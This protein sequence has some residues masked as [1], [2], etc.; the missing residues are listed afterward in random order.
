MTPRCKRCG[1]T[2]RSP[3]SVAKGIGPE[4][5]GHVHGHEPPSNSPRCAG[6]ESES[7]AQALA[8]PI[9]K[10]GYEM[11]E[12]MW[13]PEL[14]PLAEID[15][16]PWQV[17]TEDAAHVMDVA[18]SI[19][20]HE[21]IQP[22]IGRRVGGRVQLGAGHMRLAAFRYL[23]E[24]FGARGNGQAGDRYEKFPVIVRELSD[25]Q[26]AAYAIEENFKRKDLSAIE[27]GRALRRYMTDFSKT[28]AEAGERLSL[29][30]PA[31]SNLLRLLE[32]PAPVQDLVNEGELPERFA[33]QLV[34]LAHVAPED[35]VKAAQVIAETPPDDRD[36]TADLQI[37]ELLDEHGRSLSSRSGCYWPLDWRPES[38]V[39]PDVVACQACP[40]RVV[41]HGE[42]TCTNLVCF[43][44]RKAD[45]LQRELERMADKFKIAVA[46]PGESVKA[47]AVHYSNENDV[48]ALLRRKSKPDCL[49][50]MPIPDGGHEYYHA[51]ALGSKVVALGSTDT[52][53]LDREQR[54]KEARAKGVDLPADSDEARGQA[55]EQEE[56]EREER[57][58]ARSAVRRAQWDIPWLIF[59]TAEA[60]GEQLQVSGAA[61]E[62]MAD[63]VAND[64]HLPFGW[65]QYQDEQ[66]KLADQIK[67]AKG[68]A[69]EV[70][71]RRQMLAHRFADALWLGDSNQTYDWPRA[72]ET[73]QQI[74][75]ELNLKPGVGWNEPPIWKTKTNCHVCGKFTSMDHMTKRDEE[76]GWKVMAGG[77][78]V[79]SDECRAQVAK[80]YVAKKKSQ[81]ARKS[82]GKRKR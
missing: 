49:R 36:E 24:Q 42:S 38:G 75:D 23:D 7:R 9:W 40:F 33:R 14:V 67:E 62:W 21:L 53:I 69:L 11:A 63:L 6:G 57:R 41:T 50:M 13:I 81:P 78:V 72:L 26:M 16:N 43:E 66:K 30:Q 54:A 80:P 20:E 51:D 59:H 64:S 73:V 45:W 22:G 19:A 47:L 28:Q 1:R 70:L 76:E 39:M 32:L 71:M 3:E 52:L 44:A 60:C 27:K 61:L 8:W 82:Q 10:E 48:K 74:C 31:V 37:A 56:A 12:N 46:A 65:N 77:V 5:E 15:P 58:E 4:C 55:A 18:H 25:E 2:L 29:T 35:V 17:R 79:C 68:K 34:S